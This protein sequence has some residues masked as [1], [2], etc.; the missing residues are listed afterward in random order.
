[1]EYV[2]VLLAPVILVSV[3]VVG[4]I[5]TL[6]SLPGIWLM[7]VAVALYSLAV[8]DEWRID[9]S[10]LVVGVVL[11]VAVL[12]EVLETLTV[13]MGTS[14][15]GGSK[16]AALLGLCGS[17][18]G[19]LVGAFVGLPIPVVGSVLA[20][21]LFAAAGAMFGAYVGEACLNRQG[22]C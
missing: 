15:A 6:L 19:G 13:A 10:W 8:P 11:G 1:M 2:L 17:I 16:R 20:L 9:V 12:G 22:F 5:L 21:V 3:L 4:W 14:R 7:V 18:G